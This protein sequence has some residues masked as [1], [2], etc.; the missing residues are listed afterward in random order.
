MSD[1]GRVVVDAIAAAGGKSAFVALDVTKP[2]LVAGASS[3]FTG[4]VLTI[5][6]GYTAI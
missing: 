4:T 5:D 1:R 6:G 3:Y 2:D